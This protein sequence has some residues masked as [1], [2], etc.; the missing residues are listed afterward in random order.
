MVVHKKA[1]IR[2]LTTKNLETVFVRFRHP[3]IGDLH[4]LFE[5]L[6][7]QTTKGG[8]LY[9]SRRGRAPSYSTAF[10]R[11]DRPLTFYTY[12]GDRGKSRDRYRTEHGSSLPFVG[13]QNPL[14]TLPAGTLLRVSLARWWH[15]DRNA[16]DIE[17][18]CWLQLSGW[19]L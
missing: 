7:Q 6:L 3:T 14:E 8:S 15:Q 4:D 5:G 16:S 10:W 12:T 13:F 2:T 9:L 19:F 17:K 1:R 11:P 18:C